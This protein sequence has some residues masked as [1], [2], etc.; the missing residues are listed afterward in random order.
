MKRSFEI[1][2]TLLLIAQFAAAQAE[3][4]FAPES[5]HPN[6]EFGAAVASVGDGRSDVVVGAPFDT[7]GGVDAGRAYVYS[8]ADGSIIYT[9]QGTAGQ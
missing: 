5:T 8:G 6:D 2:A 3:L 1:L 7:T 4:R 9:F